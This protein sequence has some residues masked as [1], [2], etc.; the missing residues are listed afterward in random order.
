MRY[1]EAS[2]WRGRSAESLKLSKTKSLQWLRRMQEKYKI[3]GLM[4]DI[5]ASEWTFLAILGFV[6]ASL[7]LTTDVMVEVCSDGTLSH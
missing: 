3:V 5:F 1:G 6:S 2:E 4:V 7:F